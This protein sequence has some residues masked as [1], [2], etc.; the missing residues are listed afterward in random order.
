MTGERTDAQEAPRTTTTPI[1]PA[2][3]VAPI[4]VIGLA[5]R[6]PGAPDP[7][8]FWR[9]LREGR[10]AVRDVP[11]HRAGPTAGQGSVAE[12]AGGHPGIR[13]GGYL[14]A[15]DRFDP[16]FFGISPREAVAMDPQQR[17][18]LEL[19]W[20]ALEHAGMLPAA[21]RA[22]ATGV[23][24]GSLAD[25]YATVAR[26]TGP[27]RHTL[28]G[29]TRG[30]LANRVSY[31]LGLRGPSIAVDTAQS[32]S[33]VA[34]HLA[35]ESL[36]RGE[37]RL[38]L[39]GGVNLIVDP[40]ST[41]AVARFGAL[42]PDGHC[43][44]FDRRANGYVRGEGAGLVVLKPLDAALADGDRIHA[45]LLGSAVNND[46]TT[47]GLTVPSPEAQADVVRRACAAAGVS[48]ETL[49]YVELHGTGT[50]VG[51][52][53]EAR[54]LGLARDVGAQRPVLEVG[55]VKTNIGHL[56]GA[57]GIA[58]LLKTVL[59][60][61]RRELPATL[62]HAEP[63][64]D[65]DLDGLRL[66]V[67]TEAGA[68]PRADERLLAGVSSF[69]MGGTNCHVVVAEAPPEPDAG[70]TSD[71]RP[72]E[73]LVLSA[74]SAAALREQAA[75]TGRLI[76]REGG[77]PAGLAHALATTRTA[78]E[79]RA[80]ITGDVRAGLAALVGGR[81][82]PGV[83]TG[84]AGEGA[85]ALLFPG[86]GSQRLGM[87]RRAHEESPVW[88]A[89]FDE[90]A[91]SLAPHL[92][93]R[94]EDVVWAEPGTE[95]A[96]LLGRTAY[97]QPA[98]FAVEVATYRW[99]ASLGVRPAFVA[100]HSIGE[101]AAAHAVGILDL[102]QAAELIA[103]RG[104][105]MDVLPEGGGMLAVGAAEKSVDELL[106]GFAGG[107]VDIAAVNGP[108]S[109]VLSGDSGALDEIAARAAEGGLRH[110]RLDVSHAFHSSLMEP[111]LADFREAL[112]R[113]E[114]RPARVPFVSAV[115][116]DL[117]ATTDAAYW[118]EHARRPVRFE[119]AVRRLRE[120]GAGVLLEA[121]PGT[122]LSALGRD[123]TGRGAAHIPVLGKDGDPVRALGRLFAGGVDP[124]WDTVRPAGRTH[125][126]LPTYPFQRERYWLDDGTADEEADAVVPRTEPADE[127]TAA[128]AT[129]DAFPEPGFER[130][131]VEE[132]A[133]ALG[134]ADPARVDRTATFKDLGLDSLGLV[135]LRDRLSGVLG[136]ELPAATLF[137]HPTTDA[138]LAHL[139][140]AAD[141]PRESVVLPGRAVEDDPV[142]IVGMGC[143]FP[144]G[145]ASPEDLW[146][147]VADGTD[148]IGAFPTDRGWDL[149]TLF[150]ADP[151]RPGTS[152]TRHGGFLDTVAEFDAE[153]FGIS[154]REA[155]ALDPQQRLLLQTSWEA[156]ERAGID[157]H[158][159]KGSDTGVFVGATVSDYTPRLHEHGTGADGYLLTGSAPSVASGR[160]A[161]V[162]GLRGRALTVDTAC[163]SS[164]VA[165]DLA[166]RAIRSGECE[167]ALAGGVAV[168]AT[169]G[170]FVEFSR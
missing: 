26:R 119:A 133:A 156:L 138:F 56:E 158:T 38:A 91:E 27:G 24:V 18:V 116:G 14:D 22:T 169:P 40:A 137:A 102:G 55:S 19:A 95:A 152:L 115:S 53:L 13:Y 140:P 150:A 153:F 44:T 83:V 66:S 132:V 33:L 142:V 162:L 123:I 42:S 166:V 130:R 164:L 29:T 107:E 82:A 93:R 60:V 12:L 122:T 154:P 90:A 149:D 128:P 69:G 35:C 144:G 65:I 58:G 113:I 32:S 124:R 46:G 106:A 62:N 71:E 85:L 170:M 9:L 88:R 165:L 54:G 76:E 80:A 157:P 6:L 121:G 52:P 163:S 145:V 79:H 5:C 81:A 45:V 161:Y 101:V 48:P 160:I 105:L 25:E 146:R 37:S 126:D 30:I 49:Q 118:V 77:V 92:P 100:G 67:R 99:L 70:P 125:V 117:V 112:S 131:V 104:R 94:I 23:F 21:L 31:V 127:R 109:V 114:F 159:L 139:R 87:G 103:V 108:A 51:D 147:L 143:R 151:D 47:D 73:P 134:F 43:Y 59:G 10:S 2:A 86:Q 15:I 50:P 129:V 63:H 155:L 4:A 57:A 74:R 20:E 148:A 96:A 11:E 7:E 34:V 28:T 17:L 84:R 61:A 98:L 97:T 110:R 136:R 120:L 36:R 16:A 64:P 167:T 135:E 1:G 75:R 168:M 3:P 78:F 8:A 72:V 68:W 41:A 89:A 141:G 39:A 111:M